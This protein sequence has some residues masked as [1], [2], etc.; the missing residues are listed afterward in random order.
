VLRGSPAR[1]HA[2]DGRGRA[3]PVGGVSRPIWSTRR[4]VPLADALGGG[5]DALEGMPLTP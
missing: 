4:A 2:R 1:D 3:D 5:I